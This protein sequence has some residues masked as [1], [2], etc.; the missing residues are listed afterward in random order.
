M[1][2]YHDEEAFVPT[3]SFIPTESF[4][5]IQAF[6]AFPSIW[7][8]FRRKIFSLLL[9]VWPF[10][11]LVGEVWMFSRSMSSCYIQHKEEPEAIRVLFIA[12]PQLTDSMSYGYA[13]RGSLAL[14]LVEFF[15]DLYMRK[16][17]V[18]VVEHTQPYG[19]VFLGDLFDGGRVID[20]EEYEVEFERFNWIFHSDRDTPRVDLYIP[21]NHDIGFQVGDL[22]STL[23][24]RWKR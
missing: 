15:S 9:I 24:G 19:V 22:Q 10:T 18:R 14:Y 21:G 16:S 20:E 23:V 8:S 1:D 11:L 13:P 7:T 3:E 4:N 2:K 12:D 6:P 5:E 17:F